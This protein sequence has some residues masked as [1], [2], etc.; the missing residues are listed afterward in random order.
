MADWETDDEGHL[1]VS[2]L[3]GYVVAAANGEFVL[4]QL[5]LSS[6]AG[7]RETVQVVLSPE[8]AREFAEAVKSMADDLAGPPEGRRRH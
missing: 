5:R 6:E 7:G 8:D 2:P 3:A 1:V 4:L